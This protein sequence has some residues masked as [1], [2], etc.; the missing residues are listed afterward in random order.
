VTLTDPEEG[1]EDKQAEDIRGGHKGHLYGTE[2]HRWDAYTLLTVPAV[3]VPAT[4]DSKYYVMEVTL[5]NAQCAFDVQPNGNI[6]SALNW[7]MACYSDVAATT[8][9]M[10]QAREKYYESTLATWNGEDK[11]GWAVYRSNTVDPALESAWFQPL[12][13]PLDPS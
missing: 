2:M 12:S 3:A 6:P 7:K 13:L 11:V 9:T 1:W 10:D 5:E 8:W 4:A